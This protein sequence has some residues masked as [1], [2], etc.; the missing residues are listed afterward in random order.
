MDVAEAAKRGDYGKER[1][2]KIDFQRRVQEIFHKF[3]QSEPNWFCVDTS[4]QIDQIQ[5]TI[6]NEVLRIIEQDKEQSLGLLWPK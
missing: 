3:K 2:E 6:R 5:E 4:Q 1:Y